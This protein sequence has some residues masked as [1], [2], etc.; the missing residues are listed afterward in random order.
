MAVCADPALI[1]AA[2]GRY[3]DLVGMFSGKPIPCVGI[4]FGVD[5]IISVV[6]SRQKTPVRA[7]DID[8][9]VMAMGGKGFDGM[10]TERMEVAR[11]LWDA[12]IKTEFSYKVKPKFQAQ[13]KAAEAGGVPYGVILGEDELKEGMVKIK[14]MGVKD[15]NDPDFAE[16]DGVLVKKE[17]LIDEIRTRLQTLAERMEALKI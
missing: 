13:F 15:E 16:K 1:V 7:K 12:G 8:V 17:D 14:K 2:G 10:L 11:Q 3:D 4:S 9:F 5:R 6:N